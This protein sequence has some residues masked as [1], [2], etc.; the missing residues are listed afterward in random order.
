MSI[1]RYLPT[2]T[3]T[4]LVFAA[5]FMLAAWP[6]ETQ[7]ITV[8]PSKVQ[9]TADP[10][11]TVEGQLFLRNEEDTDQT[12][13]S[14]IQRFTEE[15]NT[16]SFLNKP[17]LLSDW[18]NLPGSVQLDSGDETRF[19]YSIDIPEDAPPG[20]HFGVIWWSP[21]PPAGSGTS[22]QSEQVSITTRAGILVFLNVTGD[23]EQSAN[24]SS[25]SADDSLVGGLP[26][27]L[28]LSIEN[29]G[30]T[31]ITPSGTIEVTSLL[32]N[33]RAELPVND[34]N[35]QILPGGSKT[36]SAQLTGDSWYWGPYKTEAMVRYGGQDG[37]QKVVTDMHWFWVI[38]PTS[39][40]I[41]VFVLLVLLV[42]IP[43]AFRWQR[44]RIERELRDEREV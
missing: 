7:A 6:L 4:L 13:Y 5:V 18:M 33:T 34:K 26:V 24:I 31:Y 20:G 14:S 27:D 15:G 43:L 3:V 42:G 40:S 41:G 16:K 8:G 12:F 37:E 29:D 1:K 2:I 44:R 30:T 36:L 11:D 19:D 35:K 10:G 39:T 32:G 9:V 22:S 17:T 38:P 23:T 25:F 28:S 21:S